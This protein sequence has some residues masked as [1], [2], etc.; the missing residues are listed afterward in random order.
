MLLV[1]CSVAFTRLSGATDG[2]HRT[3]VHIRLESI[4]NHQALDLSRISCPLSIV[5]SR[6]IVAIFFS[7][8]NPNVDR[9]ISF[10]GLASKGGSGKTLI[11]GKSIPRI[12]GRVLLIWVAIRDANQD[13]CHR[14]FVLDTARWDD[15]AF[16]LRWTFPRSQP[17]PNMKLQDVPRACIQTPLKA[18]T[19]RSCHSTPGSISSAR[20]RNT[21]DSFCP[22]VMFHAH[23][24]S[25]ML[26]SLLRRRDWFF[27]SDKPFL[28]PPFFSSGPIT[29]G[30]SASKYLSA[31]YIP[32]DI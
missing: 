25:C 7:P 2:V 3:S 28:T 8:L 18:Q 32:L 4:D 26:D 15:Q 30:T 10:S 27:F 29:P 19:P 22:S 1:V 12:A 6:Q 23:E 24:A 9:M 16:S 21:A 14:T 17:K 13:F 20:T 11:N 31:C 5:H